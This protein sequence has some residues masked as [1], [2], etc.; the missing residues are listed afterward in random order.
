MIF[1]M[2]FLK[3]VLYLLRIWKSILVNTMKLI[4]RPDSIINLPIPLH[5]QHLTQGQFLS[6]V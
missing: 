4:L 5:W 2:I 1:E 6:R 3:I